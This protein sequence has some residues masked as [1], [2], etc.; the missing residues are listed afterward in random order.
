MLQKIYW[1]P[2][3]V[4]RGIIVALFISRFSSGL[5]CTIEVLGNIHS[6]IWTGQIQEGFF[7]TSPFIEGDKIEQ[8]KSA[9]K[10][11]SL[12]QYCSNGF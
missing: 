2:A 5:S 12:D 7:I 4:L 3:V 11:R 10:R 9:L 8:I 1:L 6:Y